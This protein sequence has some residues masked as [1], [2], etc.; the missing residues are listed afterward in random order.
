MIV[1]GVK[2]ELLFFWIFQSKRNYTQLLFEFD[3]TKRSE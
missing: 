2:I 3:P 1:V